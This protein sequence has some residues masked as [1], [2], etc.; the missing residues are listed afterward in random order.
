MSATF[1]TSSYASQDAWRAKNPAASEIV[2]HAA[3]AGGFPASRSAANGSASDTIQRPPYA[4][5]SATASRYAPGR[6]K[7]SAG[8]AAS[9]QTAVPACIAFASR[10]RQPF[11][12]TH[13]TPVGPASASAPPRGL[14][15]PGQ[16]PRT[17]VTPSGGASGCT[18]AKPTCP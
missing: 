10:T 13:G 18:T 2:F 5:A 8:G 6:R 1:A 7:P 12:S 3:A 11:E 16:A 9:I 15:T 17:I 4:A 14:F